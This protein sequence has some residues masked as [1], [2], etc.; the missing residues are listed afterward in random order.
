MFQWGTSFKNESNLLE[1]LQ[2]FNQTLSLYVTDSHLKSDV[3]RLVSLF[4]RSMPKV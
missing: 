2:G 3:K 1:M 4:R